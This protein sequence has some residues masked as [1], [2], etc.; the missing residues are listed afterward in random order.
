MGIKSEV[1][2]AV[3]AA[4]RKVKGINAKTGAFVRE[5]FA[6]WL[7]AAKLSSAV[8]PGVPL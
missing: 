5:L 3:V 4:A 7:P 8:L 1:K 2:A 6:P